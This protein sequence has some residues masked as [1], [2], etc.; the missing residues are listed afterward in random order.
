MIYH[1]IEMYDAF[2]RGDVN[3]RDVAKSLSS[4][5]TR[6]S[7]LLSAKVA[8]AFLRSV[9]RIIAEGAA[10]GKILLVVKE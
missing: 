2:F 1:A 5:A 3:D 9:Y 8:S 4:C 7:S 10:A 6:A